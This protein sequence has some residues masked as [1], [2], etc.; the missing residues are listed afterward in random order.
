MIFGLDISIVLPIM[1]GAFLSLIS[2]IFINLAFRVAGVNFVA[3]YHSLITYSLLPLA[4]FVIVH[5]VAGDLALSLGMIGA[6]SIV[7]FR[8]PVKSQLELVAL[9]GLITMGIGYYTSVI[10]GGFVTV[11]FCFVTI[12]VSRFLYK[13]KSSL[14]AEDTG[15]KWCHFTLKDFDIAKVKGLSF[16]SRIISIASDNGSTTLSV[17][18][19]KDKAHDFVSILEE[20]EQHGKVESHHANIG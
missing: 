6:L 11:I 17:E 1:A 7:R 2:G 4:I 20:I 9:L 12:A 18:L 19:R 14:N 15:V 8:N 10:V 16:S 5:A 13:F 3:P